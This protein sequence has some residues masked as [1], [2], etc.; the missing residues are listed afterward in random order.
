MNRV[1]VL[2]AAVPMFCLASFGSTSVATV[3]SAEPV[4]L[5]GH[6]VS[7]PGVSSWPLVAG[8]EI[9]TS[10]APA[11]ILFQDG[12]SVALSAKS[13]ARL[14]GTSFRPKLVLT[15]GSLNYRLV[16]GSKVALSR[17]ADVEGDASA[18]G[19]NSGGSPSGQ[20]AGAV[21]APPQTMSHAAAIAG[22]LTAVGVVMVIPTQTLT[23]SSTS[24]LPPIST[25]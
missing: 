11:T 5:S 19:P 3:S 6:S 25:H 15:A 20:P 24:S 18:G 22:I 16:S 10:T 12:S 23:Q 14:T 13:S 17:S 8:D 7:A 1:F 21:V 2:L 4:S 9:A